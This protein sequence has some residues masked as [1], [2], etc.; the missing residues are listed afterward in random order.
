LQISDFGLR[1][2]ALTAVRQ[3][4]AGIEIKKGGLLL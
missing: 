3:A 1:L 2:P 4:Q